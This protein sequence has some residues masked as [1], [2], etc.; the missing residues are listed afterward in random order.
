[1]LNYNHLFYFYQAAKLGGVTAAARALKTSQPSLTAQIKAL[2][3]SIDRR[4]FFKS[5]RNVLLTEEGRTVFGYCRKIF[6]LAEDLESSLESRGQE[7]LSVHI[8]VSDEIE[9]PFAVEVVSR[10]ARARSGLESP[11]RVTMISEAHSKLMSRLQTNELDAVISN[12]SSIEEGIVPLVSIRMPVVLAYPVTREARARP[13]ARKR[14]SFSL[15]DPTGKP[16]PWVLPHPRLRLR[17]EI[18]TFMES[19]GFSG[20]IAF[21][22]DVLAA[23]VRAVVDGLGIA[24]LPLPYILTEVAHDKIA[25]A[26]PKAGYWDHGVWL[27]SSRR[28]RDD[29]VLQAL[30]AA[31]ELSATGSGVLTHKKR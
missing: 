7:K 20:R 31:F 21:E 29:P 26:G 9:R 15:L 22:S 24:F 1:M 2:E 19:R 23:V 27:L 11:P 12:Q 5:G 13:S 8:G 14:R 28:H 4:L 16:Y 25:V 30:K 17:G 6:E 10:L 18:D 3:A